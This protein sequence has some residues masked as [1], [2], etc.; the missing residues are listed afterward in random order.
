MLLVVGLSAWCG[1]VAGLAEVAT[2]IIRKRLFDS[3]H[4][5]GITHHFVWLIP[6]VYLVVFLAF[7]LLGCVVLLATAGRGQSLFSRLL[8]ALTL[9]PIGLVAGP[10]IYGL[11][12]LMV[13]LGLA[14]RLVPLLERNAPLFR[15]FVL[16][17]FPLALVSV[18]ALGVSVLAAERARQSQAA[19]APAP[20]AGSPNIL[21]I[22]MD[23][24]AADH[25]S[26]HGYRRPTSKTLV[27]LAEHGIRF[28][29]AQSAAP[30][31][32]PSHAAMFTGC[33]MHELAV[34]WL[35]PLDDA[36]PTLAEFLS[37]KGYATAGF[38]ANMSYCARDSGL[39]RGFTT[40]E[41]FIF[42]QLTVL[43]RTALFSHTLSGIQ[44]IVTLLE[45]E[46]EWNGV[47]PYIQNLRPWFVHDRKDAA[48]VNRELVD[49]LS[50]RPRPER[51]FFAFLN[52]FDA[53]STYE[54]PAGNFHRFG[55][56][57]ADARQ[58]AMIDHW[59]DVDKRP[60]TPQEMAF[61]VSAYDDCIADLDE[62]IG[63]LVDRL[64]VNGVLD[65]TWLIITADHGESFG[66]HSGIFS[67]GTSLYQ[68][69][70]HVPLLVVPPGGTAK[71]QVIN[72][73]VSLRYLASTIVDLARQTA[74]SPFPGTSLVHFWDKTAPGSP[75]DSRSPDPA[76][77]EVVPNPNW[78]EN[79]DSKGAAK[80]T[81]PKGALKD[82]EWSY[83]RSEEE[84][85]EELFHLRTDPNE[86]TN[87]AADPSSQ[88]TLERMRATLGRVTGG[89]LLPPRFKP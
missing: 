31:T 12:W 17:S 26:L 36:R 39:S 88:A 35:T 11:A 43:N 71:K 83:I 64:R 54:L 74:G 1:L 60:L 87:L 32:L 24:V 70:L 10:Q 61:A 28:D 47:R 51:P 46:L 62:Q 42:P 13:A 58:R 86:R 15:R 65:R 37:S 22:V 56:K 85:R 21:L 59:S 2:L 84:S 4:L 40:Y 66:E 53:H 5:Y 45:S 68:T 25:L 82:G 16:V 80:P 75:L 50:R 89:P 3:N 20:P 38:V 77:A 19:A 41:D 23:T 30:W 33:W 67:H 8:C 78:P 18:A 34:G 73:A 81:W 79:R 44:S 6:A 7:G 52:Y 69:E 55:G 29:A 76:L 72:E 14:A 27:E 49:W 9:L 48:A 63:I 57:P